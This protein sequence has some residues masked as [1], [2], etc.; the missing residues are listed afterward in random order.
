MFTAINLIPEVEVRSTLENRTHRWRDILGRQDLHLQRVALTPA[1]RRSN[2]GL[3]PHTNLNRTI[4]PITPNHS[5]QLHGF[6]S[7]WHDTRHPGLFRE[8]ERLNVP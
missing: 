6:F 2:L 8:R 7:R 4:R 1:S 5:D 3:G